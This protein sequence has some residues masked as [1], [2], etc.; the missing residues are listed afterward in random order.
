MKK[1]LPVALIL[2]FL[3]CGFGTYA[4]KAIKTRK[5]DT[6]N[7]FATVSKGDLVSKIV[8]TG[9][10]DSVRTVEVKSRV[11]GRLARLLVD[12]GDHVVQ[13]QLIAV[14]DPL[15]TK[16]LVEQNRAQLSGA[17]SSVQK[18]ALEIEQRRITA[19]AAYE[20]AKQ[21][22]VQLQAENKIQPT[23]TRS[24][25]EQAQAALNSAV[26]ERDRLAKT[27]QPNQ[28]ISAQANLREAQANYDL[29]VSD[30]QRQEGLLSKGFT[31]QRNVDSARQQVEVARA[32]LDLAKDAFERIDSQLSTD[33]AK[34]DDQVRQ[35]RASLAAAQAN[36]VQ[37]VNKRQELLSAKQ[38]L[39]KAKAAL[40]DVAIMEKA[41]NSSQSTV[42]QLS[43]V[44]N[45]AERQLRETEIRAPI[46]GMVTKRLMQE[47]ELVASLSSFSSGSPIVD[48]ED[49]HQMRVKLDVNEIDV[50]KMTLGMPAE[51]TVDALPRQ[52]LKGIVKKI[53]PSSNTSASG[54]G[55]SVVKYQVEIYVENAP[56]NL[57]TG[58]SAKCSME[59]LRKTGALQLPLEFV[60]QDGDQRFVELPPANPKDKKAVAKRVNIETGAETA[61]NVEILS[62]IAEGTKVQRPA[63][64][65][66]TR[67]GM[68][69]MGPDDGN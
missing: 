45:D 16:L 32:R 19:N 52:K 15:E 9:T 58:M 41:K 38:D 20:Q 61:V 21:R 39:E 68:M 60:G 47:G 5:T 24:A 35:A 40:Q 22:L 4:F 14:I 48:I 6:A 42:Q 36:S 12:A 23:L 13:G 44:V 8:E 37:D 46:T 51:V 34:A 65:G 7:N 62:G 64:K 57:L 3:V 27:S 18:Q 49:R 63:Y 17:M 11:S 69:Q 54:S 59:V 31:A 28:R 33:L 10:V 53:A 25:I 43:S 29:A 30:L 2:L 67:K 1:I 26:A 55:D 56:A 50:A 66:P